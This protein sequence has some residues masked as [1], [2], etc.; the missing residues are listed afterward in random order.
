MAFFDLPLD[1]LRTYR[2]EVNEPEDFEKFW[3][4]TIEQTRSHDLDVRLESVDNRQPLVDTHDLTYK[5][6]DGQDVKA[7]FIV[8]GGTRGK[9]PTVVT[10]IGYEG[11]RGFPFAS[12]WVGAGYAHLIIDTRGQGWSTPTI[13]EGTRDLDAAAGIGGFPGMMTRGIDNPE[14]YYYRRVY[15]DALR[16]VEAA[17]KL[18][19]VDSTR[20][21]LQGASQGGGISIA[22]AGLAAMS[23]VSLAGAMVDVPFLC[24][25]ERAI[26]L[27]DRLPYKEI[28]E[29]AR[30]QPGLLPAMLETLSYFDAVNFARHAEVP[31]LFSVALMDQVC[32]PSTVFAAY[33][34]WSDDHEETPDTDIKVYPHSQHEGGRETQV[35]ECLGWL[36]ERS[37]AGEPARKPRRGR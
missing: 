23:G 13:F 33:N 14:N 3:A 10:S 11:G 24:H 36:A 20:L 32:P 4:A 26:G 6:W 27:T 16:G 31:A 18:P 2:P 8:P 37:A 30:M 21:Y 35:W 1:E 22:V 15:M 17:K 25:F 34:A 29:L 5:G 28:S 9:L 12:H 7:W 19:L